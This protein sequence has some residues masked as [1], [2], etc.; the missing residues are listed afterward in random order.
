MSFDFV[1]HI[2]TTRNK[3]ELK[4]IVAVA[5]NCI[6]KDMPEAEH[7]DF[8]QMAMKRCSLEQNDPDGQLWCV[9]LT[10]ISSTTFMDY[11]FQKSI[12]VNPKVHARGARAANT[13]VMHYMA[14]HAYPRIEHDISGNRRFVS[15][16][17]VVSQFRT[18]YLCCV[19]PY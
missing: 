11:L 17:H 5:Y 1:K 18:Y 13:L 8:I 7:L 19:T 2:L 12:A 10:M 14:G 16:R 6:K 4:N 9:L 15:E 3:D